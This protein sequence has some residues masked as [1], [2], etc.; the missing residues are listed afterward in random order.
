MA[1][2]TSLLS[3]TVNCGFLEIEILRE[4]Y[5]K[6]DTAFLNVADIVW[7]DVDQFYGIEIEE[8]PAQIAQVAMWLTDHQMNQLISEEFGNYFTRLPLKKSARCC[9]N[10]LQL[11][12][13][14]IAPQVDY[15]LGNPPFVGAMVMQDAQ[16][17]DMA[18]VF[19]DLKGYGI[20]DYVASW[21]MK[22][23]RYMRGQ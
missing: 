20:L 9:G 7:L 23:A 4:L 6:L 10:A 1:A 14:A 22:T 13:G 21:Y 2:V 3:R 18:Q 17:E 5:K 16:R 19:H 11:D 12:W 15:I 8:F